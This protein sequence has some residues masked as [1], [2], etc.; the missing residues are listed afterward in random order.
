MFLKAEYR[1]SHEKRVH[2]RQ[3]VYR[4]APRAKPKP[5]TKSSDQV[6]TLSKVMYK[7]L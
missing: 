1:R 4:G 3:P 2:L 5:A 6:P 7:Y